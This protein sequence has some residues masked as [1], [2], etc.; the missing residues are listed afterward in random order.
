MTAAFGTDSSVLLPIIENALKIKGELVVDKNPSFDHVSDPKTK[1]GFNEQVYQ[2]KSWRVE[3]RRIA[4][5]QNI[6]GPADL[7]QIEYD[8]KKFPIIAPEDVLPYEKMG[9]DYIVFIHS[10]GDQGPQIKGILLGG[11]KAQ[12]EGLELFNRQL[13]QRGLIEDSLKV[14]NFDAVGKVAQQYGLATD[15]IFGI[16]YLPLPNET[17]AVSK[18][19]TDNDKKV[20][21]ELLKQNILERSRKNLCGSH[22]LQILTN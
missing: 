6:Y 12:T 18:F 5:D 20:L 8:Y 13:N 11:E 21:A 15:K 4:L 7:A 9:V 16:P 22:A 2:N 3:L 19:S 14:A 10:V 17:I 1:K